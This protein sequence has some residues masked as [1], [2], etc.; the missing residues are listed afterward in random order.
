MITVETADDVAAFANYVSPAPEESPAL[1]TAPPS[2]LPATTTA[3]PAVAAAPP[4]TLAAAVVPVPLPP[5][6]AV[7]APMSDAAAATA[8]APPLATAFST[9]WSSSDMVLPT[10]SPLAKT[11]AAAQNDYVAL[12]GTTGQVPIL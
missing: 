4:A 11:L 9:A 5:P 7:V 1:E 6:A 10:T 8:A 3:L 2:P 12:Y